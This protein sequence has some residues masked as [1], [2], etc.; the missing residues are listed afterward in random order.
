MART[1]R[2]SCVSCRLAATLSKRSTT[3]NLLCRQMKRP[4]S[5]LPL[6]RT[7]KDGSLTRHAPARSSTQ[8]SGGEG[9][10]TEEAIADIVE[11]LNYLNQRNPTAAANLDAEIA[12]CIERL[13]AQEFEGPVSR[14]RS[15]A[16]VRS[17]GVPPFRIY[18]QRHPEE[19]VIVRVYHQARR[20]ITR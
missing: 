17:W 11:A 10:Y 4:A 8:P 5:R 1:F 13:A 2:P 9:H 6:S 14:L 7:D 3:R 16:V 20:P 15:G 18:Y 19:L 12:Q